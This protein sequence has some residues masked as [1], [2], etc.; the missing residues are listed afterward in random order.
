M[1]FT[2]SKTSLER[3]LWIE[4]DYMYWFLPGCKLYFLNG[5]GGG[6]GGWGDFKIGV[7]PRLFKSTDH[8]NH[9]IALLNSEVNRYIFCK[10]TFLLIQD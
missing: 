4:F 1:Y 8:K 10:L 5:G 7:V 9:E 6:G 2:L 3:T